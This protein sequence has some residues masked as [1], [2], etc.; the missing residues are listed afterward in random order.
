MAE[1]QELIKNF[2]KCR[3]YVRDFFVYGFKSRQDF[4]SDKKSARTYDDERRRIT[5]WLGDYV[6]EDLT[7]E[8][9][10]LGKVKNISLQMDSNLLDTNPLFA[11]WKTKSFTDNDI[12]LHFYIFDAL[13]DEALSANELADL[14]SNDYELAVDT[15]L[16]RR[17]CNEYVDEGLLSAK[18][19]GKTLLY[20]LNPTWD[21]LC[22]NDTAEPLSD[23]IKLMQ[24]D[25]PYGF[26]GDTILNN[27]HTENHIFRVKHGF[28]VFTLEEEIAYSLLKAKKEQACVKIDIV[29]NRNEGKAVTHY[30]F[31]LKI[32]V[33]TRTGRRYICM[34]LIKN[35]RSKK[36]QHSN[37]AQTTSNQKSNT[38]IPMKTGSTEDI[39]PLKLK[40][41]CERLDQIKSVKQVTIHDTDENQWAQIK[42]ASEAFPD[43]LDMLNRNIPYIW[44]VSF[45]GVKTKVIL[46]LHID[47]QW[48][49]FIL[50]RL[51]REGKGGEVTKISDNTF[52]YEKTVFDANEMFPWFRTFIGRIVDIR[53]YTVSN[54]QKEDAENRLLRKHFFNDIDSLYDMY[55]IEE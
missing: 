20:R 41:H 42:S 32:F 40:F 5:S 27:I 36:K 29:S 11:V 14:L 18:K 15:Q 38:D 7:D 44:G 47:E 1:F 4:T 2:S 51:K 45:E 28:P 34:Y 23:A 33:S 37:E 22:K 17:K 8:H 46:T 35:G 43:M 54:K 24:L 49:Q 9:R 25:S 13:R 10:A 39:A 3:D 53:F 55:E 12:L 31:P 52:R 16:V 48:E 19:D 26:V 21:E 50:V 30:G 6:V